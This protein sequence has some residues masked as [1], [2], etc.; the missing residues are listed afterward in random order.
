MDF[1]ERNTLKSR[2]KKKKKP[3]GKK[4]EKRK[5]VRKML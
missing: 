3:K 1:V 4:K 5:P 2:G